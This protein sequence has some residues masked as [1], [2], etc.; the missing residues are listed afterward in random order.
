MFNF[1]EDTGYEL[2]TEEEI[3]KREDI[4]YHKRELLEGRQELER[5][6]ALSE[7][8]TLAEGQEAAN[9]LN[10]LADTSETEK[11]I[12]KC[13]AM[14]E[15]VLAWD[16]GED[17]TEFREYILR[18]LTGERDSLEASLNRREVSQEGVLSPEAAFQKRLDDAKWQVKYHGEQLEKAKQRAEERVKWIMGLKAALEKE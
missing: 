13:R 15:Q 16:C 14:I 9:F 11:F 6:E 12:T 18:H 7:E 10:K 17:Y 4:N 3:W 5:L 1:R 2:P 8:E